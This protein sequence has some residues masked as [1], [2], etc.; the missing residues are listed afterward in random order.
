MCSV[1]TSDPLVFLHL[2]GVDICEADV[3]CETDVRFC[4][5][6]PVRAYIIVLPGVALRL[7]PAIIMS[8]LTG[9]QSESLPVI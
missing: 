9:F 5:R 6:F 3:R 7:P 4:H 2:E 8:P 1:K